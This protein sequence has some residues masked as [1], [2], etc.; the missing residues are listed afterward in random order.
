VWLLYKK[1]TKNASML[2]LHGEFGVAYSIEQGG[3]Q[4][5]VFSPSV[6]IPLPNGQEKE[7]EQEQVREQEQEQEKEQEQEQVREQEQE[8]EQY[9]VQSGG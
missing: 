9:R 8:Q 3:F 4:H 7:Q 2:R 5:H 1:N 6:Q